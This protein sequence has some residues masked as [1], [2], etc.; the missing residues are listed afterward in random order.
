MKPIGIVALPELME[1]EFP[2]VLEECKR[3]SCG[4]VYFIQAGDDGPIKIGW[5]ID[6]W[7]RMATLQTGNPQTLHLR[8]WVTGTRSMERYLHRQFRADRIRGEWFAP[9][10]EL[11]RFINEGAIWCEGGCL[12]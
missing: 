6:P 4:R 12:L 8:R 5:A 11:V 2:D 3:T 10:K 7:D 1:M 9:S